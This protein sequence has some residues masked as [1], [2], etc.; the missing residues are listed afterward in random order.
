MFLM[1]FG[2]LQ[3]T[4]LYSLNFFR[5]QNMFN[6]FENVGFTKDEF[7]LT[8]ILKRALRM[9]PL[10]ICLISYQAMNNLNHLSLP[11]WL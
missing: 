4:A 8:L 6:L 9:E 1:Y 5:N 10:L 7:I 3:N 2:V 11:V